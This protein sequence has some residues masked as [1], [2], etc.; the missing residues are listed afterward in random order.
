MKIR[1]DEESPYGQEILCLIGLVASLQDEE[2]TYTSA[3]IHDTLSEIA[4]TALRI[5]KRIDR[6]EKAF[7]EGI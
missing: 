2:K 3:E 1:Y 7:T 5:R 6:I 4:A